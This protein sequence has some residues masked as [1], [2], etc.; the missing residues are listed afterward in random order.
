M[1]QKG[2]FVYMLLSLLRHFNLLED[3]EC[4]IDI[5]IKIPKCIVWWEIAT[6]EFCCPTT[7]CVTLGELLL[8]LSLRF[9]VCERM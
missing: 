5:G 9:L 2:L 7:C 8:F 1:G 4:F 6:Q 3:K